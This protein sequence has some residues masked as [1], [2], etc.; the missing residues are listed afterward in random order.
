MVV[1]EHRAVESEAPHSVMQI[2]S[3][4]HREGHFVSWPGKHRARKSVSDGGGQSHV[5]SAS[6]LTRAT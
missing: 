3:L 6:A 2:N 1:G 4:L 5:G